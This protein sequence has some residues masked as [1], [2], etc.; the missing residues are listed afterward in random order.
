M[1]SFL[2][3]VI[4]L[5][6]L[7]TTKLKQGLERSVGRDYAKAIMCCIECCLGCL[8]RFIAV[9]RVRAYVDFRCTMNP[10]LLA[11]TEFIEDAMEWLGTVVIVAVGCASTWVAVEKWGWAGE[12]T[13]LTTPL[14]ASFVIGFAIACI[15]MNV[16]DTITST[17]LMTFLHDKDD[18]GDDDVF[19]PD[20]LRGIIHK[21]EAA[22]KEPLLFHVHDVIELRRPHEGVRL[23]AERRVDTQGG[24]YT[25]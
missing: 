2:I 17:L 21:A 22:G 19:M 7:L 13:Q 4:R 25:D 16:I 10:V 8:E 11:M 14:A 5:L 20:D 15:F 23:S 24:A 9:V 3:A 18:P 12:G 1:G 6:R